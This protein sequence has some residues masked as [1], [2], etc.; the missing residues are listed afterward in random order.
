LKTANEV[1]DRIYKEQHRVLDFVLDAKDEDIF[2]LLQVNEAYLDAL[3]G[4]TRYL[5]LEESMKKSIFDL[6]KKVVEGDTDAYNEFLAF[7][8]ST[9]RGIKRIFDRITQQN[10]FSES[11]YK[12]IKH[13]FDDAI[14]RNQFIEK[15]N[16][17]NNQLEF[18]SLELQYAPYPVEGKIVANVE[19][20]F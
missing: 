9:Q 18:S 17:F 14:S 19:V 2:S 16:I 8:P 12:M 6:F 1:V 7:D 5:Q 13:I 11:S 15:I 3:T 20:V 4:V 10:E